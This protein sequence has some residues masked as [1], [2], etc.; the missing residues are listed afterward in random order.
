MNKNVGGMDKILRIVVGIALLAFAIIGK[1]ATGY[2]YLGWI[3]IVPLLTALLGWCP[4]YTLLGIK[5]CP[6]QD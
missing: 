6:T 4:A 5:T 1:P 2:N 3:G